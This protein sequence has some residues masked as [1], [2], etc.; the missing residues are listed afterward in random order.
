[1]PAQDHRPASGVPPIQMTKVTTTP[2]QWFDTFSKHLFKYQLAKADEKGIIHHRRIWRHQRRTLRSLWAR[3]YLRSCFKVYFQALQFQV[4]T[5]SW[6]L[7][8]YNIRT[9]H[10]LTC[11]RAKINFKEITQNDHL[12][13]NQLKFFQN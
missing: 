12:W 6:A 9:V 1:M 3:E 7:F 13:K 5:L 10:T 2:V 11:I 8:R 4:S